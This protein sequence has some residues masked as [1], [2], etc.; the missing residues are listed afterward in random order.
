MAR[1]KPYNANQSML[2]PITLSEHIYE[3]SLEEAIHLVVEE[4]LD[5]S[6][7]DSFYKNDDT[8]RPAIHPKVLIKVIL[9]AYSKG[10]IG[11]R[12]I[13]KATRDNVIFLALAGGIKPDHSTIAAFI[14][15]MKNEIMN[16]FIQVLLI[17]DQMDLLGGTH[18]SLDGCPE[19]M[20][21]A[22]AAF[23]CFQRMERHV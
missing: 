22:Q 10:I 4:R 9:L 5:L 12:R 7:F 3:G 14:S 13:E 17:C 8:G 18:L 6:V 16:V 19:G 23:K 2:V 1:Y 11:S 21:L 15:T 20:P